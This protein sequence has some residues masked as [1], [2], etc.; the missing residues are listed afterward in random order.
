LTTVDND[1]SS[2]AKERSGL[3]ADD[4]GLADLERGASIR[5]VIGLAM[6]SGL[7]ARGLAPALPGL[8]VGMESSIAVAARI[9]A[10]LSLVAVAGALAA[11]ARLTARTFADTSLDATYR[12]MAVPAGLCVGVLAV[13]SI[14]QNLNP[15]LCLVLA[16]AATGPVLLAAPMALR[17]PEYRAAGLVLSMTGGAGLLHVLGRAIALHAA[18]EA[19]VSGFRLSQWIETIATVVDVTT[20]GL[21]GTYLARRASRRARWILG[22]LGLVLFGLVLAASKGA[23]PDSA[24]WQVLAGRTLDQFLRNPDPFLPRV[25]RHAIEVSGLLLAGVS[26]AASGAAG[27]VGTLF[28]AC[29][30]GRG[31]ADIPMPALILLLAGLLVPFPIAASK[32]KPPASN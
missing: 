23:Q 28:A 2:P 7:L 20:L 30:M 6:V 26:L 10:V 15:E 32:P 16:F 31:A 19:S 24:W 27:R 14:F 25:L 3:H 12:F 8:A 9:A 21:V 22:G 18:E 17:R 5:T 11:S 4:R 13:A 29:L 1:V